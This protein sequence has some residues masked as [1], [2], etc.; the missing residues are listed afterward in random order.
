MNEC[1]DFVSEYQSFD[2]IKYI[3]SKRKVFQQT[4]KTMVKGVCHASL[5]TIHIFYQLYLIGWFYCRRKPLTCR[6]SLTN[7]IT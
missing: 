3:Q 5:V 2:W 1:F 4:K 6:K 7:F